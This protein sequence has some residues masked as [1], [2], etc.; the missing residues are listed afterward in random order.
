MY[1][2]YPRPR[3]ARSVTVWTTVTGGSKPHLPRVFSRAAWPTGRCDKAA[4]SCTAGLRRHR[5]GWWQLHGKS[6]AATMPA[7]KKLHQRQIQA[8]DAEIDALVYGLYELTEEEVAI[9]E[10]RHD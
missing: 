9:V 5:R 1:C 3:T 6:S 8:S 10:G 7:D 4:D 2:E